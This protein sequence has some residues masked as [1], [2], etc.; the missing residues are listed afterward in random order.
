MS[1]EMTTPTGAAILTVVADFDPPPQLTL[2][3]VGYGAGRADLPGVPNVTSV[4]L[5]HA[6][7]KPAEP[8]VL[9]ETNID[10]AQGVVMGY[11]QERLFALGALDVWMTP[12]Q[13]KKNRPGTHVTVLA[14]PERREAVCAT[15]F[16]ETSTIGLRYGEVTREVLAREIVPVATVYGEIRC[17]VARRGPAVVNVAPEFEDC[18]RAAREHRASAKEVHAAAVQAS[19]DA[20]LAAEARRR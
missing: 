19:R 6:T 9:L 8:V 14:P 3:S 5:G 15:L 17:K 4:W 11:A 12:I 18:A 1:H 13:M 7:E 2:H 16:R 10:D 20:G